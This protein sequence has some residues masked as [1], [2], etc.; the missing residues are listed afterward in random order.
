MKYYYPHTPLNR[1]RH[2]S[3]W[4]AYVDGCITAAVTFALCIIV[5]GALLF[6]APAETGASATTTT[7]EPLPV[8]AVNIDIP[9]SLSGER[10]RVFEF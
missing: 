4:S 7:P 1:T 8:E 2:D 9:V 3:Y 10:E 5:A 6:P